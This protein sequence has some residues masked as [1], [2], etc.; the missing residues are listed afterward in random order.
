MK[1][2]NG[3][4]IDR[5][6]IEVFDKSTQRMVDEMRLFDREEAIKYCITQSAK[7]HGVSVIARNRRMEGKALI[8]DFVAA[9]K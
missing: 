2:I 8:L 7:G 4:K 5:Y 6:C 3:L 9:I 1:R